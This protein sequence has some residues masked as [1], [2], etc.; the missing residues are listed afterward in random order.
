[1]LFYNSVLDMQGKG[2]EVL[3]DGIT[4]EVL[5]R[6]YDGILLASSGSLNCSG[7]SDINTLAA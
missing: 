7:Q 6:F 5:A 2:L 4:G 3:I 1:M